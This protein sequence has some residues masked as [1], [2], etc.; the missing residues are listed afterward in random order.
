MNNILILM[1]ANIINSFGINKLK[2]GTKGER[3]KTIVLGIV[4][5]YAIIYVFAS[6]FVLSYFSGKELQKLNSLELLLTSGILLAT[7]VSL[8]ISIYKI[9]GY[10]FAFKDFD[11]LMSLPLKPS[12]VLSCKMVFIY[13]SNLAVSVVLS[14]PPAIIYGYF[15]SEGFLYYVFVLILTLFVPLV[16]ISIGAVFAYVIGRLSSKVRSTNAVMIVL[17]LLLCGSIIGGSSL[18]SNINT[19][20]IKGAIPAFN[21]TSKVLFWTEFYSKALM[22]NNIPYLLAFVVF[23]G[24]VFAAFIRIFSKGFKSINGIMSEKYKAA[25]YK[26]TTLKVTSPFVALYKKELKTYF[27]SFIYVTNTAIGP[28]MMTVFTVGTAFFGKEKM[29]KMMEFP[30][31]ATLITPII[32]VVFAFC[33]GMTFTTAASIS[34]EGKNLWILKTI[35]VKVKYILWSK[36]LVN[37][38]L[39]IPSVIINSII[40]SIGFKLNAEATGIVLVISLVYCLFSAV[41]GILLNLFFPKL[42]WTSQVAVV[43]QGASVLVNLLV[44]MLS[45]AIPAILFNIV[46]PSNINLFFW[47]IG[48]VLIAINI[49]LLRMLAGV[50]V[51]KFE[52]L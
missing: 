42:E 21:N 8:F 43:K 15:N 10:L 31:L 18:M 22:S 20:Q 23:S 46:K 39:T 32:L 14:V 49:V 16:P 9:P 34:I 2:S 41:A 45:I 37:L 52:L 24:L 19:Q 36:I 4:I 40:A 44:T 27:S 38:T 30:M 29:A 5:A 51:R 33:I 12:E 35:P 11:L 25:N 28:I 1:K 48:A 7:I 13:L 50:G 17:S 3:I 26:M 47:L 6:M